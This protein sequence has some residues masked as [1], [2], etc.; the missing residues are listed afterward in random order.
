MYVNDYTLSKEE[1]S[2]EI[3]ILDVLD[4][5]N[6]TPHSST[7]YTPMELKDTIDENLIEQVKANIKNTVGKKIMKNNENLLA[8]GDK[9]L[10]Y[11]N[12]EL[13]NKY[14]IIKKIIKKKGSFKIPAIF[15]NYTKNNLLNITVSK[16]YLNIL[17]E[18]ENY[19]IKN[20]LV[21]LV[22]DDGFN[23]YLESE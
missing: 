4:F 16:N 12:I 21:S 2:L 8:K 23:Y 22:G 14:Q 13:N 3:A 6:N 5:H 15:Q 20:D 18:N 7:K 9:L 10:I 17:E 11:N 1:F 19:I